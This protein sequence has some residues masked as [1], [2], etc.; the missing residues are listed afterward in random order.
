MAWDRAGCVSAHQ[1][2]GAG[3][4]LQRRG[5]QQGLHVRHAS[6]CTASNVPF[7]TK[8]CTCLYAQDG[9]DHRC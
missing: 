6:G 8:L 7:L 4:E 2:T 9:C 1:V 3:L 5:I